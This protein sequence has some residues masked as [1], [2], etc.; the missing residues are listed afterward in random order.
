[1]LVSRHFV[2]KEVEM[3]LL[4]NHTLKEGK[5]GKDNLR[6]ITLNPKSE[7]PLKK[8]NFKNLVES[9]T[10]EKKDIESYDPYYIGL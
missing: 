2:K 4:Q 6:S 7:P 8:E 3:A 10:R 5:R 1:M 9:K